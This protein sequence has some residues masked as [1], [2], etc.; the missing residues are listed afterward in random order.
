M[1]FDLHFI[2]TRKLGVSVHFLSFSRKFIASK[3]DTEQVKTVFRQGRLRRESGTTRRSS[4][5]CVFDGHCRADCASGAP[6]RSRRS[7]DVPVGRHGLK[8]P[9]MAGRPSAKIGR[10]RPPARSLRLGERA[11]PTLRH[12]RAA[13]CEPGSEI[14]RRLG[15]VLML[16]A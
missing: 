3:V 4:L 10:Q 14:Y 6:P 12:E 9:P 11:N 2:N 8:Y 1:G 15:L 5:H 13:S 16:R 7:A